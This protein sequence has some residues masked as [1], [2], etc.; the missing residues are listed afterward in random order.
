MTDFLES[1]RNLDDMS[2][3]FFLRGSPKKK[4]L[5]VELGRKTP[6]FKVQKSNG[7]NHSRE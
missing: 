5:V 7:E 4:M 6:S 3:V 1:V 2:H